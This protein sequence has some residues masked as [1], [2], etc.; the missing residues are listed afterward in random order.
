MSTEDRDNLPDDAATALA[1]LLSRAADGHGKLPP[2]ERWDPA[3]CGAI[4]I[5]ID[6]DGG[7]H[8]LGTPI[9][10]APLVRLFSTVLRREPDGSYVLVTPA[11][12]LTIRVDDVPF[13]AVEMIAEDEGPARRLTFRTNLGDIAVADADRP[14]RFPE[15][16]GGG[17]VPYLTVRGGLEARLTRA[18]AVDLAGLVEVDASGRAGVWSGGVFHALPSGAG[19]ALGKA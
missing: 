4:D 19:A 2:V 11:E 6:R 5:R 16:P 12:K 7:W 9:H 1:A 15:E 18:L 17:F 10:R 13:L 8:Y 14:L 3:N